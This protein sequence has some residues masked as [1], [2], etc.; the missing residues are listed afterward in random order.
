MTSSRCT[1]YVF[2][3]SMAQR[4]SRWAADEGYGKGGN[5]I[6]LMRAVH[7]LFAWHDQVW[8]WALYPLTGVELAPS[9]MQAA[10]KMQSRLSCR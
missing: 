7:P 9:P 8:T 2:T 10:S 4:K 5:P 6:L 3:F 1:R